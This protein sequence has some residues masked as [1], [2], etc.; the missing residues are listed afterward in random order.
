MA[1]L[2]TKLIARAASLIR[3]TGIVRFARLKA[4]H[5]KRDIP[6]AINARASPAIRSRIFRCR[7]A[8]KIFCALFQSG[9]S[10]VRRR[11][12]KA[13]KNFFPAIIAA[14]SFSAEPENAAS[15]VQ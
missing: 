11:L 12:L 5:G 10:W 7:K 1:I 3:F 13:K 9:E 15:A 4:V 6:A 8:R 2:P 14:H